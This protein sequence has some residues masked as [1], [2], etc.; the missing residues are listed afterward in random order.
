MTRLLPLYVS[1]AALSLAGCNEKTTETPEDGRDINPENYPVQTQYSGRVMNGYLEGAR[2]WLDLDGNGL[3]T[4]GTVEVELES[5]S[6]AVVEGGE[7]TVVS[8]EN[9][10]FT[11]DVSSLQQEVTVAPDLDPQD[12]RLHALVIPGT[13]TELTKEGKVTL[14]RAY[15]LSALSGTR[16]VSPLSTLQAK[17]RDYGTATGLTDRLAGLN[18]QDDY[19]QSDNDRGRTYSTMLTRFMRDQL[20]E[21]YTN[22]LRGKDGLDFV[23]PDDALE[24]LGIALVQNANEL[25]GIV[26]EAAGGDFGS[27]NVRDLALPD[28]ELELEDPQL[29]TGQ[30]VSLPGTGT[31]LE[32]AAEMAFSYGS[33]ARLRAI[34]ADGCMQ[35]SLFEI[36]RLVNADGKIADTGTQWLPSV[37]LSESSVTYLE[38]EE[39]WAGIDERLSFDW[40]AG[41]ATLDTRTDCHGA[42]GVTE[43]DGSAEITYSWE[44]SEGQVTSITAENVSTGEA[45]TLVPDY[46][47]EG[48]V[49]FGYELQENGAALETFTLTSS[50]LSACTAEPTTDENYD[51]Q[52]PGL[53]TATRQ[54]GYSVGADPEVTG[55]L[56]YNER[57]AETPRLLQFGLPGASGVWGISAAA[58]FNWSFEYVSD[59]ELSAGLISSAGLDFNNVVPD[60]ERGCWTTVNAGGSDAS[61]DYSYQSLSE[62]LTSLND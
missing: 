5:G 53:V 40:A 49:L 48:V 30:T 14:E 45:S 59:D 41:T 52:A 12:Y 51:P 21:E 60:P 37:S 58:G 23:V 50:D 16:N 56:R 62:Y 43:L 26:D 18:L 9:G 10:R 55:Y 29:L 38:D 17:I 35:P 32:V 24:L 39:T 3:Y 6:V 4:A 22:D 61:V 1:L 8:G 33:D 42:N 25:L 7:P 11:L 34:E 19:I 54:F 57:Q 46:G 15:I 44:T 36:A 47:N 20:P 31:S 28:L 13:T 2:V 27:V